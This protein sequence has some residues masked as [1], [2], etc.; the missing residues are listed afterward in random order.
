MGFQIVQPSADPHWNDWLRRFNDATIFH[1]AG[2]AR[3]L[4]D[5]YGY[6]PHFGIVTDSRGI[7]GLLP[8]MEVKS[9]LT[10]KRGVSLPFSDECSS[11]LRDGVNISELLDPMCKFGLSRKWSYL[12]LHS[13]TPSHAGGS[14]GSRFLAHNF[15]LERTDQEQFAKLKDSNRRNIRKA[16][17]LGVVVHRLQTRDSIDAY[18]ELHCMTRQRQG[19]LPQPRRFFHLIHDHII[20]KGDGHVLLAEYEGQ[21][22]AGGVYLTFGEMCLYKFGAS[23]YAF[24]HLRASNLVMWEAI[25]YF[26]SIGAKMFSFGRTE[27]E[28]SGLLQFKRS[29]GANEYT[30]PYTRIGL[31]EKIR[32]KSADSV[33]GATVAKAV[34]QRIPVPMLRVM[35]KLAYRHVA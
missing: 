14:P 5:C 24:Q 22:I 35:G 32:P 20:S 13:A 10:G 28:N 3:T 31:A 34:L 18:Y 6:T 29:W 30:L 23:N 17:K 27:P 8:L 9:S 26:R 11:L 2:W 4:A 1:T 25:K 7:V 15:M 16:E 33:F 12:D 19:T 21:W